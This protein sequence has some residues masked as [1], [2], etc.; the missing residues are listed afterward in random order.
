MNN[1][2][3]NPYLLTPNNLERVEQNT[4]SINQLRNLKQ[5]GINALHRLGRMRPINRNPTNADPKTLLRNQLLGR[6]RQQEPQPGA[7][8]AAAPDAVQPGELQ[9]GELYKGGRRRTT[10]HKHR[11]HK[12]THKSKRRYRR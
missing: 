3:S 4:L 8:S 1:N 2:N 12:Q 11:K 10:R 5:K 9:P 6:E 7:A